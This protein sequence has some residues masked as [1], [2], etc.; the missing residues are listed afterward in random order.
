MLATCVMHSMTLLCC[1]SFNAG[2][3]RTIL[4]QLMPG[5]PRRSNVVVS[6]AAVDTFQGLFACT[7]LPVEIELIS[8]L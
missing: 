2:L 6:A 5:V 8:W 1:H 3:W 4:L 7:H